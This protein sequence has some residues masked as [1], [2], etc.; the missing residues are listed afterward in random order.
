MLKTLDDFRRII[1]DV[2]FRDFEFVID[3]PRLWIYRP[4]VLREFDRRFSNDEYYMPKELDTRA[5]PYAGSIMQTGR[6]CGNYYLPRPPV[7]EDKFLDFIIRCCATL[8]LHEI[9]ENFYY[10]GERVFDPHIKE[11]LPQKMGVM[12]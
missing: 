3:S 4:C 12:Y 5:I 9:Q 6:I 7:S 11:F 10:C 1:K 2:V 8:E